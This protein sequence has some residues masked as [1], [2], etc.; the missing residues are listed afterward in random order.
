MQWEPFTA[1]PSLVSV[2]GQV[3]H[4]QDCSSD[5]HPLSLAFQQTLWA[6]AVAGCLEYARIVLDLFP[7]SRMVRSYC[8]TLCLHV[9]CSLHRLIGGRSA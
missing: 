2:A 5:E 9:Y 8:L 3:A 6:A 7:T 1:R 4:W